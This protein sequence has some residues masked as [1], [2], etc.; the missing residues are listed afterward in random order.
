VPHEWVVPLPGRPP[1]W[2]AGLAARSA[3]R[4][5]IDAILAL[6]TSCEIANDGVSEIHPSDIAQT[7]DLVQSDDRVLVVDDGGEVVAWATVVGD[8]ADV[9]VHPDHRG[10]RIGA[11]LIAWTE[12][13]ARASGRTRVRQVVTDADIAARRLFEM[14]G[15]LAVQSSWVLENPLQDTPPAVEVPSGIVLRPYEPADAEAVYRVIEDAFNEWPGRE[16]A[17]FEQWA[18]HVR[19]HAAF[20]PSLSRVAFDGGQLVGAVLCLDYDGEDEGWVQQLATA[21]THRHRGIARALLGS[22][23]LAFHGTGKRRVGLSTN[24][25]T[26]ALSLYERL[27]M[28]IRRSYTGWARDL[29]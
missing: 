28:R 25:R 18:A 2:P 15:Y 17:S 3:T 12:E 29:D 20:A 13:R 6:V 27:G 11:A 9:D 24:S 26:G 4:G 1:E 16:P 21:A 19:D 7:F 8:R 5:D 14:H 22:A 23:F 10:R